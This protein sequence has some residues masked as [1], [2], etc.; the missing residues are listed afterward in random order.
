MAS[1]QECVFHLSVRICLHSHLS[2]NVKIRK[3]RTIILPAVLYWFET[4]SHLK[5]SN[6]VKDVRK[7]AL[8]I[9]IEI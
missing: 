2:E 9:N 4:V 6:L 1:G 3:F 8:N 5:G 7:G